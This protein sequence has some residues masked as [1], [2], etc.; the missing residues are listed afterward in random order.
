MQTLRMGCFSSDESAES[1]SLQPPDKGVCVAQFRKGKMIKFLSVWLGLCLKANQVQFSCVE[2]LPRCM[3]DK[4]F[5]SLVFYLISFTLVAA[6]TA[7]RS[8]CLLCS[9]LLVLAPF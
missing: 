3:V 6:C 1:S 9:A 7:D 5:P 2:F 8:S 4:S